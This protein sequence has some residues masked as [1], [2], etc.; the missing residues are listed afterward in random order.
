MEHQLLLRIV[1]RVKMENYVYIIAYEWPELK[2][3]P[4]LYNRLSERLETTEQ[5]GHK[6]E[7]NNNF[8]CMRCCCN[9][10]F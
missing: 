10:L 6:G 2:R 4:V 8:S 1:S 3:K 7:K 5:S 9:I